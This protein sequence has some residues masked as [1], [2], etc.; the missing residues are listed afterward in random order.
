MASSISKL[1]PFLL[2]LT[3][4]ALGGCLKLQPAHMRSQQPP[5]YGYIEARAE[6]F[7]FW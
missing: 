7:T 1:G 3:S 2:L 6:A 4:A 5:Q